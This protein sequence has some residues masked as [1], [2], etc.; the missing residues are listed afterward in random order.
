M[1]KQETS[2]SKK[3]IKLKHFYYSHQM[4]ENVYSM[5][6]MLKY[7]RSWLDWLNSVRSQYSLC[8][9]N[10]LTIICVSCK[11][12]QRLQNIYFFI[13]SIRY[14]WTFHSFKLIQRY[15]SVYLPLLLIN[16]YSIFALQL[17]HLWFQLPQASGFQLQQVIKF[18]LPHLY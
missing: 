5:L 2:V 12:L 8:W 9:L 6:L 1:L 11:K 18:N 10:L 4:S 3:A 15:D 17:H 16:I 7:Q 14:F 13:R